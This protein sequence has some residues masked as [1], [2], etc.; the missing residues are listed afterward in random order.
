M[1]TDSG[2][3][4]S[5]KVRVVGVG[6]VH[7]PLA[8]AKEQVMLFEEL[9]KVSSFFKK[10][11]HRPKKREVYFFIKALGYQMRFVQEYK[12]S[13]QKDGRA[14]MDWRVKSGQLAGMVGHYRFRKV[15]EKQTEI[16]LWANLDRQ[17]LPLPTFLL[18]FTLEVIAEK[19]AQKM[20]SFIEDKYR[21]SH[22][23]RK[24]NVEK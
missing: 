12:W 14:Q 19:T 8:F 2:D 4:V 9:P 18:G 5:S 22:A 16:A 24:T 3:P 11:V 20:R 15:T 10:V 1:D 6:A 13:Q 17:S 7:V 23:A 21:K